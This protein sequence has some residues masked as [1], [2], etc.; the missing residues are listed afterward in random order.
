MLDG[1]TGLP[2]FDSKLTVTGS[3]PRERTKFTGE[4][5]TAVAPLAGLWLKTDPTGAV[6]W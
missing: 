3:G 1:E 2:P 4:S 5:I 6:G